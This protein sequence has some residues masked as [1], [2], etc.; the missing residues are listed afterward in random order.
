MFPSSP[1]RAEPTSLDILHDE[2]HRQNADALASLDAA[3]AQAV[4]IAERIRETGR[5]S[6]LG[7]GASH[8]ANRMVL[9][10]YRSLGIDADADVL[11]EALRLPRAVR[12]RVILLTSQS[13][14]SGEVRVWLERH[15]DH[16]DAFGLTMQADSLL[17][18]TVSCMVGQGGRERAFAATRSVMVTL[19]LHAAVLEA[20]GMDTSE[21][22]RLWHLPPVTASVPE[23]A[24]DRL[25]RC[26][27]LVLASRGACVPVLECAALTFMELARTPALALE[28]GQLIHGPQEAIGRRNAL[29]LVRPQGA[30]A[31]GVTRFAAAAVSWDVPVVLFDLG[32]HHPMVDSATI[33][34]L[35]PASGLVALAGLLPALQSLAIAAAARRVP[36]MGVPQRSSKV[37]DG[38]AA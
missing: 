10:F 5:L 36:D 13:G 28:L 32:A 37:T 24:I 15:R 1:A 25:A 38:E 12:P 20:L 14:D 11:S 33:V 4:R 34:K 18:R 27:T 23:Q 8:W 35:P 16:A 30:D 9:G 6:M 29:V 2:M 31:A 22:R 7:M 19:A 21:L 3:R 26:D 17:G